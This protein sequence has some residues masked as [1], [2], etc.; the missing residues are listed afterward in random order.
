LEG[1]NKKAQTSKRKLARKG[2]MGCDVQQ[3][4]PEP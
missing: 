3:K 1:R 4:E 2:A